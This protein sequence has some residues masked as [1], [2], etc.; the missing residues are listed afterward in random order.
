M[1]GQIQGGY[2][3]LA[4]KLFDSWLMDKPPLWMKLWVWMLGKANWKNRGQLK[5]GQF[6]TTINEMQEAMSYQ[7]GY[8]K[9]TPTRDE[10]RTA[11]R[12]FCENPHE[13]HAKPPMIT[14]AKTTRGMVIT[15]RNYIKYQDFRSYEDHSEPHNENQ[16]KPTVTP[17]DTESIG[18]K[19]LKNNN[20]KTPRAKISTLYCQAFQKVVVP[21]FLWPQL[22][23]IVA[24]YPM[25]EIESAFVKFAASNGKTL[26]Y[27]IGI[28]E[29]R[30]DKPKKQAEK[31]K[32]PLDGWKP[33][34]VLA[35]EALEK[36]Q[37]ANAG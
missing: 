32:D 18:S 15:I 36:E 2:I 19:E 12:A 7:V 35:L 33:P 3:L 37:A 16:A 24:K 14:I 29:K 31:K 11:Y 22:D 9:I 10:I 20:T 8:R 6:V 1:E 26:D 28:L 23:S 13:D 34:H 5:R 4:R 25:E 21:P 27:V 17:H 30:G